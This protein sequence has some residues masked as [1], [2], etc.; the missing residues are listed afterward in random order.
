MSD[1]DSDYAIFEHK[2]LITIADG[3]YNL[4]KYDIFI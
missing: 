2:C 1:L 3:E 4:Y